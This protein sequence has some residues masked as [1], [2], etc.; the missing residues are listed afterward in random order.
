MG[1]R[2]IEVKLEN[3]KEAIRKCQCCK[4]GKLIVIAA[5]DQRGPPK[6]YLG[7]SQTSTSPKCYLLGKEN[8]VLSTIKHE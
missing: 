2:S 8:C 3:K 7:I 1:I 6:F 4:E 5:F